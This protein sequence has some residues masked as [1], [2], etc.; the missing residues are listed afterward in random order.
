MCWI[1]NQPIEV[2]YKK[3]VFKNFAIF[4]GKYLCWS[5]FLIRLQAWRP[6]NLLKRD[7]NTDI[8][9][10]NIAIFLR[11]PVLKTICKRLVLWIQRMN[12]QQWW[13][14]ISIVK[15]YL[16][17]FQKTGKDLPKLSSI[18]K[19]KGDICLIFKIK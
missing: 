16:S 5:L 14:T 3:A 9:I 19:P 12:S 8:F 18:P 11:A 17:S 10:V 13:N 1:Q 4:T 2:Y 6:A 7:S 15:N